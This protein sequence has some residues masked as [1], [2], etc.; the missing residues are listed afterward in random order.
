MRLRSARRMPRERSATRNASR[1]SRRGSAP[2]VTAIAGDAPPERALVQQ[3]EPSAPSA[4]AS[5]PVDSVTCRTSI[6]RPKNSARPAPGRASG[7]ARCWPRSRRCCAPVHAPAVR[8][9][10][11][12]PRDDARV[13]G[14]RAV[15]PVPDEPVLDP[16]GDQ[17]AREQQ[18]AGERGEEQAVGPSSVS[19][20]ST[21]GRRSW[22]ISGAPN[23]RGPSH[24]TAST[25]GIT[26]SEVAEDA[27][28]LRADQV[29]D[30]VDEA[31]DRVRRWTRR[32]ASRP[33]PAPSSPAAWS[34][35]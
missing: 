32:R 29:R 25:T 24:C 16:A 20:S 7:R 14:D 17:R 8:A 26:A 18:H 35:P 4:A 10:R 33:S 28:G 23:G 34:R 2:P 19:D 13:P 12:E 3:A 30:L 21:C 1:S 15:E 31:L 11:A 9:R 6:G 22:P 27:G 5:W